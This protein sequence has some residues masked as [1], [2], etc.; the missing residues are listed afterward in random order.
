MAYNIYII[1]HKRTSFI[2]IDQATRM[3]PLHMP[4]FHQECLWS[5]AQ[6]GWEEGPVSIPPFAHSQLSCSED[7]E[8]AFGT[9][10]L[11]VSFPCKLVA[12]SQAL[13]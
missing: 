9:L 11:K 12:S 4:S 5:S 6:I 10:K 13:H 8:E 7:N 3:P 1:C 2:N